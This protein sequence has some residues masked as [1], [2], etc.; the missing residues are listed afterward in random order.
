MT[1]H[2]DECPKMEVSCELGC[3]VVMCREDSTQHLEVHCPEKELKCPFAKYN[4][5]GL[6]KRKEMSKRLE[7]K[8]MEH[9]ELKLNWNYMEESEIIAKQKE[10]IVEQSVMIETMSQEIKS[11]KKEMRDLCYIPIKLEWR[12]T[13]LPDSIHD[14]TLKRFIV[15]GYHLNFHFC[16]FGHF[17]IIICPQSGWYYEKLKWP[18]KAEFITR[19][20]SHGNPLYIKEFKSEVVV[21]EKQHFNSDS[22]KRFI[23]ARISKDEFMKNPY[24]GGV[25]DIDIICI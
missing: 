24:I 25:A 14:N 6:I 11:L 20:N 3:G 18:F 7:E 22:N 10:K 21:V 4:C 16:L 23:I 9:L 17:Q 8:R 13:K 12:I 2:L 1:N 15:A 5:V 19:L